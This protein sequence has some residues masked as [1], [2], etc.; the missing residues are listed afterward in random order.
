VFHTRNKYS[1]Y[2]GNVQGIDKFSVL[3]YDGRMK[4]LRED[5]ITIIN[6]SIQANLPDAAVK[7]ALAG[8]DFGGRKVYLAAIGKAAWTM[9]SAAME[10][11]GETI[12]RG[13]VVTKYGHSMGPIPRLEIVEAGHPVPDENTI[14]GTVKAV[15]MAEKLGE[16]D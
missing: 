10:T 3:C 7:N 6:S 2:V 13:V 16:G 4:N 9:A 5:A 14:A 8:H 15:E 11:L 1:E 12:E